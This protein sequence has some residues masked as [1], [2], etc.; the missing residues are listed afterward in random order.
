MAWRRFGALS[1]LMWTKVI[2]ACMRH[3]ASIS[4]LQIYPL[5]WILFYATGIAVLS[6]CL[7]VIQLSVTWV[8]QKSLYKSLYN[9]ARS[10]ILYV[11][12]SAWSVILYVYNSAWSVIYVIN[13][14]IDC[15]PFGAYLLAILFT[16]SYTN[17]YK[18]LIEA[19]SMSSKESRI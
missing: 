5:L 1:K 15:N 16:C 3:S 7:L 11:Y 14:I 9:S 2:D 6:S 4:W 17:K 12:N 8:W 13:W 19:H 18:S 10:V